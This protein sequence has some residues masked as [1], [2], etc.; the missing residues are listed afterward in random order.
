MVETQ[1]MKRVMW[2]LLIVLLASLPT[3]SAAQRRRDREHHERERRERDE[4]L[5][6]EERERDGE[7]HDRERRE[8]GERE[9]RRRF[10]DRDDDMDWDDDMDEGMDDD[11]G[12]DGDDFED[13][14][15][16][17]RRRRGWDDDEELS[18]EKFLDY[19][20]HGTPERERAAIA[21]LI[22]EH[23]GAELREA[24]LLTDEEPEEAAEI[25]GDVVEEAWE[26]LELREEA[27]EEF[28]GIVREMR[29]EREAEE[30]AEKITKSRGKDREEV[31]G[32][33][34]KVLQQA[35][36][37]RQR[38]MKAEVAEMEDELTNLKKLIEKRQ[39]HRDAIVERRMKQLTDEQDFLDW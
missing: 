12:W 1:S 24:K 8:D 36:D 20:L 34:Q 26:L 6:R 2:W 29:L 16:H 18:V 7:H 13:D 33:L 31:K 14:R 35:F 3:D 17:R 21:R 28:E 30:L 37:L 4:H 19:E 22:D 5:E 23:F 10:R 15:H 9:E 25:V 27:P 11:M 39:Q 38:E 32:A